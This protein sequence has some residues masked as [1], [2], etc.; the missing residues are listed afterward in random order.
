MA[1]IETRKLSNGKKTFHVAYEALDGN[2]HR[3]TGFTVKRDA[4][5]FSDWFNRLAL[6]CKIG[7]ELPPA[8]LE[9]LEG[10]SDEVHSK[11]AAD[12]FCVPRAPSGTL[13]D[14]IENFLNGD[15]AR[16]NKESTIRSR[17]TM[18]R[19]WLAFWPE[20]KRVSS[21][22]F[23]DAKD[24][25]KYHSEHYAVDTWGREIKSLKQIFN[26]AVEELHWIKENPFRK[27][28]G[29]SK[30]G[31]TTKHF[32]TVEETRLILGE[33]PTAEMRLIFSLARFGGLR[34]PSEL[35][36]MEWNDV[37]Y[38]RNT[39]TVKIPKKTDK[40][41]EAAG[42]YETREIPLFP[43]LRQAFTEYWEILPEGSSNFV[44]P[45]CPSNQ[46]LKGRFA[47]ILRRA[48]VTMWKKFF[49]S[50]RSTRDTELRTHYPAHSV[51]AWIGH[52]QD[53]AEKHYIQITAKDLETAAQFQTMT[54][55]TPAV[56]PVVVPVVVKMVE[57]GNDSKTRN[58]QKINGEINY[59]PENTG[60]KSPRG[61]QKNLLAISRKEANLTSMGLEPMPRP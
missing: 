35:K 20:N 8:L 4:E 53:V 59:T 26:Y 5:R 38:D 39:L 40:K 54:E 42:K 14:L 58:L 57:Q 36:A 43:E 46:A 15:E 47:D 12:G 45:N 18:S 34:I 48:G 2:R 27:L 16:E 31:T 9:W 55:K 29:G 10:L 28:K 6:A 11:L 41:N 1:W 44:F 13:N 32:V 22:T 3:I 52:G 33:C 7:N 50:M 24:Y 25:Q 17:R 56:N 30:G 51:N 49:N 23:Q 21:F 61:T 37:H 19:R 60:Y